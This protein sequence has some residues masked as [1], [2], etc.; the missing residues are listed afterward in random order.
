MSD[1]RE[2]RIVTSS[3]SSRGLGDSIAKLTSAL[4][5]K[6]CGGCKKRQAYL[7]KKMPYK[8]RM[9]DADS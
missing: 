8:T 3:G 9:I 1:N 5:I 4:G 7:N 6:P 2:P